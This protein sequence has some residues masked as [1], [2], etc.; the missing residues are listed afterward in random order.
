[1]MM[2]RE[3]HDPMGQKVTKR[4]QRADSPVTD[5]GGTSSC[6]SGHGTM[7]ATSDNDYPLPA[8]SGC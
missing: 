4:A 3:N 8:H 7:T 5:V 6:P 2:N 1:M